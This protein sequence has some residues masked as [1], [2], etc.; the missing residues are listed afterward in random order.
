MA[1]SGQIHSLNYKTEV[2][3]NKPNQLANLNYAI[4]I[5]ME[6]GF[7]GIRYSQVDN[8]S[9]AISGD[10]APVRISHFTGIFHLTE[11][12]FFLKGDAIHNWRKHFNLFR[13]R[14]MA[15]KPHTLG[16]ISI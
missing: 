15:R 5:R 4:C 3:D 11:A 1:A 7:C 13:N 8:F 6:S 10:A 14:V 2:Q 16:S 9:F 12:S